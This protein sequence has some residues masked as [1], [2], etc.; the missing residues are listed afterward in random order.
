[1]TPPLHTP[2]SRNPVTLPRHGR[3]R[4]RPPPDA[5]LHLYP[6]TAGDSQES[7]RAGQV[8]GR[9]HRS[10]GR[11]RRAGDPVAPLLP[12]EDQFLLC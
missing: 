12:A 9:R 7:H 5:S 1:M 4:L 6:Q 10:P 3:H 11:L 2:G 8:A